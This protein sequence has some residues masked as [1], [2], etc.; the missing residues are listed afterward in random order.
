MKKFF[1]AALPALFLLTGCNKD[2]SFEETYSYKTYNI[3]YPINSTRKPSVGYGNYKF[4]FIDNLPESFT[5]SDLYIGSEEYSLTVSGFTSRS[6][7][8]DNGSLF[9]F[10]GGKGSLS[11]GLQVNDLHGCVTGIVNYA[12]DSVIGIPPISPDEYGPHCF[13]DYKLGDKYLVK[14]I[15]RDIYFKGTTNTWYNYKGEEKTYMNSEIL[16]RIV[17]NSTFD[18]ADLVIYKG[19][20]AEEQPTQAVYKYLL[21]KDLPVVLKDGGFTIEG[22]NIVPLYP[23]GDQLEMQPRFVF[24]DIKIKNTSDNLSKINITY[25]VAGQY[26][27]E[28][29]GSYAETNI[30]E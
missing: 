18:K 27:G 16:Y 29:N 15:F 6:G 3:I 14:T 11:N 5:I 30:W 13:I 7:F 22:D 10:S 17:F 28:F 21:L 25:N 2:A 9:E 19:K 26:K 20:F 23:E 8:T 12:M 4:H 1:L 24:N